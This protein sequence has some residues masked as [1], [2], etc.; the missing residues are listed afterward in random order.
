MKRSHREM[1]D[2]TGSNGVSRGHQ[3]KISRKIRACKCYNFPRTSSIFCSPQSIR[4]ALTRPTSFPSRVQFFSKWSLRLSSALPGF[5]IRVLCLSRFS[6]HHH[7]CTC[8]IKLRGCACR[9][10]MPKPKNQVRHRA[11]RC[12]MRP[13][14]EAW[15][16]LC[17]Q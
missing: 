15:T 12:I 6:T 4:A 3:P 9:P 17:R 5:F 1:S 10:R 8:I 16:A 11:W 13:M 7:F 14:P 2:A